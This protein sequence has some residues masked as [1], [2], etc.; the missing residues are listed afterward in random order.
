MNAGTAPMRP[1]SGISTASSASEGI[2]CT[3]P[4]A[5]RITPSVAGRFAAR[6]PSGMPM[7]MLA[8]SERNTSA[9]CS[10]VSR[11]EIGTEELAARKRLPAA[12]PRSAAAPAFGAR[13]RKSAAIGG[14]VLALELGRGVH[15]PHRS[16]RRS[17]LRASRAPPRSSA[18]AAADRRDRAAPR[19]SA[20]SN[21][22][23]RRA[24]SGRT[25]RSWR[26]S[27]RCRSRRP[28]AARS[29]RRRARDRVRA[30]W[31]TADRT[32][33]SVPASRRRG[34]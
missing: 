16:R 2:V 5:P 29:R 11:A 14:E 8:A 21:C 25:C 1:V 15:P 30:A 32:R 26:R 20:E 12:S 22:D 7:T 4:V 23:R 10:S 18:G 9:R 19:R 3:T 34:R 24:R 27:S 17:C 28:A 31:R 13:A 6:M 33:A